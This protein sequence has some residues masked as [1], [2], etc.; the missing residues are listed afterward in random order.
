MKVVRDFGRP[1][2]AWLANAGVSPGA[3]ADRVTATR[4]AYIQVLLARLA[5]AGAYIMM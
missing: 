1:T 3:A 4:H 5:G 2:A